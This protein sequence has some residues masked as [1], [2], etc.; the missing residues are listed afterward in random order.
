M[1]RICLIVMAAVFLLLSACG[2]GA[3]AE[4]AGLT[5][6]ATT[7]P[8]YL[9][10]KEVAAGVDGV[11]VEL[12][13]NQEVS[14]L[15]DYTL[16]I[17]DM[18]AIEGADLILINGVE[19]ESF[20]DDALEGREIV[21]CSE[22]IS[23]L[24]SAEHNH[25]EDEHDHDHDHGEYDPHIWMDPGRA[26]QMAENIAAGLAAADPE[27]ASQ[28][29]S[30]GD[31]AFAALT[32]LREE[33]REELAGLSCRELI[34]FHDGFGYFADA[35]DLDIL[36]AIEEEEGSEAS[37]REIV[38]IVGYVEE[39]A[40]P[41]IFVETNGSDATANAISRECGVEV[42][43]LSMLMSGPVDDD[44]VTYASLMRENIAVLLEALS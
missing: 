28:Y 24:C 20:L 4:T 5:V 11:E 21:D 35:L 14:C 33:L 2:G 31:A 23:L 29:A 10:A 12:V 27:H 13:I 38:E 25:E 37:A 26:A 19:L 32:D 40:L 6:A 15:H 44:S 41:A 7:Y 30:N 42:Y 1:K 34:T 9:L 36:A 39:Y 43:A 22:G 17:A 8:V 18:K 16:T 3:P